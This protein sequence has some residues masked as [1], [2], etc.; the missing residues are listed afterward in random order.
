M[1]HPQII[2]PA[3]LPDPTPFGYSTAVIA[4]TGARIAH[5]SGQG[6][7]DQTGA[8]PEDFAGQVTLAL[9]NLIAVLDA[10]GAGHAQVVKLTLYVVDHDVTKLP[11]LTE[12]ITTTFAPTLPAQTLVPVPALALPGMRFEVEAV[13]A[14]EG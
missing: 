9:G 12:A 11:I 8:L 2:N 7:F 6:G 1:T 13:T 10:V 5:I 3:H 14:L 4:P